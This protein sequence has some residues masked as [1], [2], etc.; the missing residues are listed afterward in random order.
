MM[1]HLVIFFHLL[2]CL[3]NQTVTSEEIDAKIAQL[4]TQ[5]EDCF[6]DDS[7]YHCVKPGT[8]HMKQPI[9]MFITP[10][11]KIGYEHVVTHADKIDM[12]APVW[13]YVEKNKKTGVY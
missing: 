10:W 3:V 1:K 12:V 9:L 7:D 6:S 13:F 11:N 5:E 2:A 8:R 4:Q